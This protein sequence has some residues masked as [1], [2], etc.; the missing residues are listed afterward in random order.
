[1]KP[2]KAWACTGSNGK[3]FVTEITPHPACIGRLQVYLLERDARRNDDRVIEVEIRA[4]PK[5]VKRCR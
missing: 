1:M 3:I 2:I 4:V 5:K